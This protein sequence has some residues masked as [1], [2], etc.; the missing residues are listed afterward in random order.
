[1]L[2]YNP[3]KYHFLEIQHP[4]VPSS[5]TRY[6]PD[7]H[8]VHKDTCSQNTQTCKNKIQKKKNLKSDHIAHLRCFSPHSFLLHH[9]T[10]SWTCGTE[11]PWL[12]DS[13]TDTGL[14][15]LALAW[16]Y[17]TSWI[18]VLPALIDTWWLNDGRNKRLLTFAY[19]HCRAG[20]KLVYL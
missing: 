15:P 1:M 14:E 16:D 6:T 9:G 4:L 17:C 8:M 13:P 18:A 11:R 12:H 3:I 2:A 5:H 10:W 19:H 7:T 20:I